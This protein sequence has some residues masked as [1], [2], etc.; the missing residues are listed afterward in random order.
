MA[1]LYS[2]ENF[3]QPSVEELRQLGHD[4]VTLVEAGH[5][6]QAVPDER[7]LALATAAGRI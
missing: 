5:A 4:V 3:P 1:Q 6:N 7:V 2:D